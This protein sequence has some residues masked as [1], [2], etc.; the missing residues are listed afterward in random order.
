MGAGPFYKVSVRKIQ[1]VVRQSAEC[2]GETIRNV[3]SS[4]LGRLPTKS[5]TTKH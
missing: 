4:E 5:Q 3:E 2:P 1:Y